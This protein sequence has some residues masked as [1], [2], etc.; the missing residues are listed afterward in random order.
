MGFR[1][2]KH[3]V[4]EDYA[5]VFTQAAESFQAAVRSAKEIGE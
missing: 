1:D 5:S 3:R 2:L 4:S